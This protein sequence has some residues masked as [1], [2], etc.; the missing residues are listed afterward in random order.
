MELDE[1]KCV[2][3]CVG[4]RSVFLITRYVLYGWLKSQLHRGERV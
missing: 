2:C 4:G 3:V 1:R